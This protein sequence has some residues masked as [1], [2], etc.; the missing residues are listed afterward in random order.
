MINKPVRM[1][2]GQNTETSAYPNGFNDA[3]DQW[4]SYLNEI[5]QGLKALIKEY[6]TQDNRITA[7]PIYV[8]VQEF[9]CIGVMADGYSV[10]CPYGDGETRIQYKHEDL[11]ECYESRDEIVAALGE[12]E[13]ES[14]E[15]KIAINQI[16]EIN[17][18]YIWTPVEFFLTIKGAEQ[19]MRANAHNHGKL[20]TYVHWF[21]RRNFEMR[22]LL[23]IV[24]FK[25]KD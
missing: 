20:R 18:G 10:N 3:Y 6:E 8:T 5:H 11:E 19:Y 7:Y 14:I 15:L 13:L 24:G 1:D 17:V 21:E 23:E 9:V 4:E 25:T 16:E 2:N 12:Y 22:K